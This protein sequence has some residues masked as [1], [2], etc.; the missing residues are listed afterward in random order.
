MAVYPTFS[1]STLFPFLVVLLFIST[2]LCDCFRTQSAGVRGTLMCGGET[3]YYNKI[4]YFKLKIA[5]KPLA[6]TKV[7]KGKNF[8]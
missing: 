1:S 3:K 8:F 4:N 6:D 5:E 7:R 2:P